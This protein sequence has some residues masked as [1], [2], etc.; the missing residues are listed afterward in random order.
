MRSDISAGRLDAASLAEDLSQ[1]EDSIQVSRRI[2]GGMLR[3]ARGGT[4]PDAGADVRQ[5]V[6]NTLAILKEGLSRRGIQI[7][8]A[9]EPGLPSLPGLRGDME[10]LFLNLLTNAR[11]A[12]PTG[13]HLTV[14]ARRAGASL[15]LAVEDTGTGIA[16]EHLPKIME[17]FYSTKP[18]GNGLGLS[19]CRSIVWQ[20]RG[21]LDIRSAPGQ[22]TRVSAVIPLSPAGGS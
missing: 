2:F 19:I 5:S 16:S 14:S 18:G 3:F 11:D 22:G 9:I 21:K 6:D 20:L 4:V 15:E 12:M 1:I 10:Q 17:P 8:L 13:G 7:E